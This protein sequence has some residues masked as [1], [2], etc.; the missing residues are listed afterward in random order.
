E[1][2]LAYFDRLGQTPYASSSFA[3]LF[4]PQDSSE[5]FLRFAREIPDRVDRYQGEMLVASTDPEGGLGDRVPS[6]IVQE[7]ASLPSG[8]RWIERRIGGQLYDLYCVRERDGEKTVGYLTFGLKRHG[9]IA[10]LSLLGR[11]LLVTLALTAGLL[12]ILTITPWVHSGLAA[13]LNAPRFGFRERVIAGFLVVSLLPTVFLGGAGRGLFVQEKRRQFQDRL[14]EDLRVSR[15]LLSHSLLDAASSAAAGKE[16]Q[17]LLR[18]ESS[19]H[20]LADP[21]SV[22]AI[23]LRG[24]DGGVRAASFGVTPEMT[25]IALQAP[26]TSS[27]PLEFFRRRGQALYACAM[28]P[29]SGGA[30]FA[31]QKIDDVLASELERRVGSPV[32]FFTGGVLSATSKP[33]LYQ[34]EVL[35]DLVDSR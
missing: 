30:V 13:R 3:S 17:A 18:G 32:S 9:S 33:E 25:S 7:L 29:A 22:D 16:V 5:D 35:S 4:D 10:A 19:A 6:V 20:T 8:G 24:A 15:E 31:F 12:A 27:A 21:I 26:A 2:Q 23:V 14:E 34:S 1:M 11:S 28:A